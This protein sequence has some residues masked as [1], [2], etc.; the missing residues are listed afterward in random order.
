[1]FIRDCWYGIAWD[2]EITD[3]KLFSR[4]VLGEPVLVYRSAAGALVALQDRCCHRHAPLSAGR[5]EGDCVRCGCHRLMFDAQGRCVGLPGLDSV[6]PKAR[7]QTCPVVLKNKWGFVWMGAPGQADTALLPDNFSCNHPDWRDI[8]GHMHN[9]VN[10]QQICDNL[11]DFSH[12]SWVHGRRS[13]TARRLHVRVP[14]S[15]PC[16]TARPA[17]HAPRARR[18]GAAVLTALP[19]F[20]DPPEPLVHLRLRAARHAAHAF[21][22]PAGGR[23]RGRQQPCGAAA[24]L[25][26]A[27]AGDGHQHALLLPAVAPRRRRRRAHRAVDLRQPDRR[28]QRRPQHDPRAS[29]HHRAAARCADAAAGHGRRTAAFSAADAELQRE[30]TAAG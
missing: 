27:D 8:P 29:P 2:H 21:G 11:L 23:R 6:P 12:L 25:P 1:M 22:R 19:P 15:R 5:R 26:D 4:T 3:D 14:R 13:A 7:V 24:Q 18:A 10:Y 28:L 20:R 30:H 17:R 16:R 9:D